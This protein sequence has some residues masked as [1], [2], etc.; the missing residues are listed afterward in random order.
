VTSHDAWGQVIQ[1]TARDVPT[2]AEQ[3]DEGANKQR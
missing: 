3:R 1:G 2:D